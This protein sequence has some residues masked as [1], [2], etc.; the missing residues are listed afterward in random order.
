VIWG[1]RGVVRS[2][3]GEK[4]IELLGD[5]QVIEIKIFI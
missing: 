4:P 2:S 1:F 3:I 5:L